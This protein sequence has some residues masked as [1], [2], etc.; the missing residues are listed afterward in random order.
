MNTNL[1]WLLAILLQLYRH[2]YLH[3][4]EFLP[5]LH[6][7][8]KIFEALLQN[9]KNVTLFEIVVQTGISVQKVSVFFLQVLFLCYAVPSFAVQSY[10]CTYVATTKPVMLHGTQNKMLT[11][12][13]CTQQDATLTALQFYSEHG[14]NRP[15][16]CRKP[17]KMTFFGPVFQISLVI[18]VT[19]GHQRQNFN[20]LAK[21]IYK[22]FT[23]SKLK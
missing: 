10:F 15:Q 20:T 4:N 23:T 3:P 2:R 6:E 5:F 1:Y 14:Q 16:K 17:A 9:F 21:H 22:V 19:V 11:Y 7:K 12:F 13:S 18:K 8:N